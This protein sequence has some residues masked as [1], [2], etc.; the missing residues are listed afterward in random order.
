MI[1]GTRLAEALSKSKRVATAA[2]RHGWYLG[3]ESF[4]DKLLGLVDQARAKIRKR[5]HHSGGAVAAH[6]AQEAERILRVLAA[7]LG[8]P[9]GTGVLAELRKGHPGKVACVALLLAKS[10]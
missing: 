7:G 10:L 3:E 4:R 1:A 5:G 9:S 6:H 8:L 2:L